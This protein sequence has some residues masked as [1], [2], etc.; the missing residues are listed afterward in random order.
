[1]KK[2]QYIL[3]DNK[4]GHALLEDGVASLVEECRGIVRDRLAKSLSAASGEILAEQL[5]QGD[6]LGK[7][8]TFLAELSA[9]LSGLAAGVFKHPVLLDLAGSQP[10]LLSGGCPA[11]V[12]KVLGEQLA[13]SRETHAW[14]SVL[15]EACTLVW[16]RAVSDCAWPVRRLKPGKLL[17]RLTGCTPADEKE[18][19]LQ[20]LTR[21][22]EGIKV[23]MQKRLFKEICFQVA[24]QVWSL[25][26]CVSQEKDAGDF[27]DPETGYCA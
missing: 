5:W 6:I 4:A 25:Y 23:N 17:W 11:G 20:E 21:S 19:C 7:L 14:N 24:T 12:V 16:N 3:T 26:D 10:N 1:M 9:E 18:R 27:V 8:Q 22:V 15:M 13:W 2:R